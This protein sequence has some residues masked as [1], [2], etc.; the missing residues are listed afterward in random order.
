MFCYMCALFGH[1]EE[2]CFLPSSEMLSGK[3]GTRE[4]VGDHPYDQH[5]MQLNTTSGEVRAE[6]GAM[7]GESGKFALTLDQ[8]AGS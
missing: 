1:G 8:E 4:L 2:G 3:V 7:T 6:P 5:A